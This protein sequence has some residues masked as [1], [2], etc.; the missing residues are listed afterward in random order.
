MDE[1]ANAPRKEEEHFCSRK[2]SLAE[3]SA[4]PYPE[5]KKV[6]GMQI[7]VSQER[8]SPAA[9]G[10]MMCSRESLAYSLRQKSLLDLLTILTK[11]RQSLPYLL[12]LLPGYHLLLL[13]VCF[14]FPLYFGSGERGPSVRL[15]TQHSACIPR[16]LRP[17]RCSESRVNQ[18]FAQWPDFPVQYRLGVLHSAPRGSSTSPRG[19]KCTPR[20][21]Y[22]GAL[23]GFN[24]R[25]FKCSEIFS[26]SVST[27]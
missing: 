7:R 26:N 5:R 16:H 22:T 10:S 27:P 18:L 6:N 11:G 23:G 1:A 12:L 9:S 17:G 8:K 14:F 20:E 21:H 4:P 2:K 24:A 3:C 15:S 13:S 25:T 19:F